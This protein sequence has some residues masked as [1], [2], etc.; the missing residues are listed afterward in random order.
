V[1]VPESTNVPPPILMRLPVPP[2]VPAKIVL[3]LSLPVVKLADPSVTLPAPASEP[4][5][6]SKLPRLSVAPDA[7]VKALLGA[8][9]FAAPA[10][11]FRH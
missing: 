8:K 2:I 5:V 10:S 11:A 3:V 1:F 6:W 4:M 9:A 7:T